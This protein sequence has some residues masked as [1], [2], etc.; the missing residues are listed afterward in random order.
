MRAEVPRGLPTGP[1]GFEVVAT[2]P[3][4]PF[5]RDTILAC[6]SRRGPPERLADL[7]EKRVAEGQ[8]V[9]RAARAAA[10]A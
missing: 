10:A 9:G 2:A 7:F 5:D 6:Q 8:D 1:A 3:A 4:T